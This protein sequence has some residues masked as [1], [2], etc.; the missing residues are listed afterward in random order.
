MLVSKLWYI[1]QIYT[2]PKYQKGNWRKN[3]QFPLEQEKYN[4]LDGELDSTFG[5]AD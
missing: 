5:G 1:G 2:I 3:I 4:L